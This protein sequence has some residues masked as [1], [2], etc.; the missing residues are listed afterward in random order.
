MLLHKS[1]LLFHF[2][3]FKVVELLEE[4]A[5]RCRLRMN[6]DKSVCIKS[7]CMIFNGEQDEQEQIGGV[8]VVS[9]MK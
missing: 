6:R 5:G 2:L 7:V 9:D 3:R 1:P 4:E 8:R